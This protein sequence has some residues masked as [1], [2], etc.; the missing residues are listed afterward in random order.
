MILFV[1]H[2]ASLTGAPK[3]L[4]LIIKHVKQNYSGEVKIILGDKG[5]LFEEYCQLGE[6]FIWNRQ[7]KYEKNLYLRIINRVY[8]SNKKIQ[9]RILKK[10]SLNK[11][12]IIFN[13]TVNNGE[14]LLRLSTLKVKVISRIPEL[15]TVIN[16]YK[17]A[18][19]KS[20][21]NVFKYSTLFITPSKAGRRHLNLNEKIDY[22]KI[23]VCYGAV[24][25]KD[26]AVNKSERTELKH[27]LGVNQNSFVIGGCGSLG[28]RKGSDL[29]LQVA[30]CLK[31]YNEITFIWI[32]AIPKSLEYFQFIYEAKKLGVLDKVII[33][34]KTKNLSKYYSA[35]DVFLMTSREDPFPLVNLEA[36]SYGLPII[37]FKD[38]GGTEEIIDKSSGFIVPYGHTKEIAKKILL[39]KNSKSLY[40]KFS[41][42][43]KLKSNKF[44]NIESLNKI[45]KIIN[46]HINS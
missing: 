25:L 45:Y 23:H 20:T 33:I 10:L 39:L 38:S 24:N 3:S 40:K 32:G 28:W 18:L 41:N 43:A 6:V 34:N 35:M 15:E 31:T 11:P 13:N 26:F 7:W 2:D 29:F 8:F 19:N 27:Q 12:K 1:G 36:L 42:G 21:L 5:P 46:Q 22:K 9:S 44:N 16:Y 14:I 17:H 30:C 4:L 37:C